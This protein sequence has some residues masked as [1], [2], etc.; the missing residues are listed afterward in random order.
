LTLVLLHFRFCGQK[1]RQGVKKFMTVI[2]K[3]CIARK[4]D[5]VAKI[6][7]YPKVKVLIPIKPV[8]LKLS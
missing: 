8:A 4:I 7:K 2:P 5:W 6:V 3:L 1:T